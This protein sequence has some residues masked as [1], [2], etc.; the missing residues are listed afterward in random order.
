MLFLEYT[1]N[2]LNTGILYGLIAIGYT[3]VYG[4][5][6]LINFAHGEICMLGAMVTATFLGW[7]FGVDAI[8]I[9]A[10][11]FVVFMT[12]AALMDGGFGILLDKIAYK[13]LRG[14]SRLSALITAIGMSLLL[15]NLAV[16]IWGAGANT[17]K[18]PEGYTST[19][20]LQ[21]GGRLGIRITFFHISIWLFTIASMSGLYFLVQKTRFGMAMRATAQNPTAASLMGVR[22]DKVVATTFFVGSFLGA[23]GGV[24]VAIN[25]GSFD[26]QIGLYIGL[27]AFAAAV[28]GGIGSIPGAMLGG[29]IIGVVEAWAAGYLSEI[30]HPLVEG[31][32]STGYK[33]AVG[34]TVLILIILLRPQGLLGSRGGDRA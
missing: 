15:Q 19:A 30:P 25:K 7:A 34:F 31:G 10:A 3:M 9:P 14:S 21:I 2:G 24:A 13:P 4:I 5:I 28:L 20:I 32:I 16:M 18:V 22:L 11:G 33:E 6:Q 12:L 26:Y 8:A 27:V 1:L 29:I 17:I 23:I